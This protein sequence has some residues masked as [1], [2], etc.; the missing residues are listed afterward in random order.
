MKEGTAKYNPN[1]DRNLAI[2]DGLF[3]AHVIK[4]ESNNL[5]TKDGPRVVFNL[6]YRVSEEAEK[7]ANI[8]Y[9]KP[10][11]DGRAEPIMTPSR[12]K[13]GVELFNE[14]GDNIMVQESGSAAYMVG[15]RIRDNGVWFNPY[16]SSGKGWQNNEYREL[17]E[18]FNINIPEENGIQTLGEVEELDVL[19]K[20]CIIRIAP[21]SYVDRNTKEKKWTMRALNVLPWE[22]GKELSA[23]IV[24]KEMKKEKQEEAPF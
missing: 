10:G 13:D 24:E 2:S 12:D 17:L 5:K 23:K 3:K 11:Q 7:I 19:Y 20:P 22:N 6:T 16:P 21:S 1:T 8:N 14:N 4:F 15:K 9:F 18:V